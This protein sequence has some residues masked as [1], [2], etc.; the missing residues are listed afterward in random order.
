MKSAGT[1]SKRV[2]NPLRLCLW[3]RGSLPCCPSFPNAAR[4]FMQQALPSISWHPKPE[5]LNPKPSGTETR[6]SRL[7]LW[8]GRG[9]TIISYQNFS[10]GIMAMLSWPTLANYILAWYC[11]ETGLRLLM[12]SE[13]LACRSYPTT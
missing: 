7:R 6:S 9:L 11:Y 1:G 12:S 13:Y 3:Q 10:S 5:T 8:H 2:A 4:L